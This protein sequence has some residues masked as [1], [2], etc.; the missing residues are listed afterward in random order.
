MGPANSAGP[1]GGLGTGAGGVMSF[2]GLKPLEPLDQHGVKE[3]AG[4]S[5]PSV[6]SWSALGPT[7][8]PLRPLRGRI[9]RPLG[10]A[11]I[12]IPQMPLIVLDL[13][14]IQKRG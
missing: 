4:Q 1:L 11:K 7:A 8:D 5:P 9:H 13:M 14:A 12:S 2:S 3:R 6:S 10:G